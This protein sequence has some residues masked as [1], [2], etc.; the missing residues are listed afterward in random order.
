MGVEHVLLQ[1]PFPRTE[2][3]LPCLF[4]LSHMM[5]FHTLFISQ[6]IFWSYCRLG[7]SP[8]VNL[9]NY[10]G[11]TP[12]RLDTVYVGRPILQSTGTKD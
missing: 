2:D 11:I 8:K 3:I 9:V 1:T 12:Y 7:W 4:I 6:P 5:P 10:R